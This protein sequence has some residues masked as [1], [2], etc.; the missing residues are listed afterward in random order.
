MFRFILGTWIA[1]ELYNIARDTILNKDE[2]VL[3]KL[4]G[5]TKT[6]I[7]T[8]IGNDLVD[9]GIVGFIAYIILYAGIAYYFY[10]T[11]I[12]SNSPNTENTGME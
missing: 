11:L 6:E 1:G 3:S 8:A 2:S 5:G 7:I 9:G 10:R 12:E 4:K